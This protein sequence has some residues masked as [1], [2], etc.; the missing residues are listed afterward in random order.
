[1]H[2]IR[3]P[4]P[5][6]VLGL[7]LAPWIHGV[8]YFNQWAV[9]IL[10]GPDNAER[11]ARDLGYVNRGQIDNFKNVYFMEKSDHPQRSKRDA[12]HL[13]KR[14]TDDVR[15]VWAE[16][17]YAKKRV[18][19]RV[20]D[21]SAQEEHFF[22]DPL[23]PHQWYLKDTRDLR[24]YE[25]PKLDLNVK[26]CWKQ[27]FTGKDI[28]VS[29]VDDGLEWN[30]TDIK[31]NY[32]YVG[33]VLLDLDPYAST[34]VNDNDSDPFP[35][36]DAYNSNRHGTRCAG[37]IAMVANNAKC[38]VGVAYNAKIGGIRMLDGSLSDIVEGRALS[39]NVTH[40]DVFSASW[41]PS[42]DGR[43]VDGPG[44]LAQEAIQM[45]IKKGRKGK[46][47]IYVW[48]SGNGGIKGDNCNC[49]GY[50]GSI[51]TLSIGSASQH[52][53]FPWYGEK[54][55]STLACTYSSGAYTDQKISST[56]LHNECTID[57]TGTSAA[58]P[59]AAGIVALILEAKPK[60]TWRDV[61]HLVVWTSDYENLKKNS[62]WATN[63]IGLK[64]NSKFGFGMMN[65]ARMLKVA[66][67]WITV[68]EKHI[69][70]VE[71]SEKF[72]KAISSD[73]Q[74]EI[75]FNLKD[76]DVEYLEHVQVVVNIEYK[77]RGAL[78]IDLQS[79]S[80]TKTN[81]LFPRSKDVSSYGFQNWTFMSVHTW[82]ENPHGQWTAVIADKTSETN[83]GKVISAKLVVHGTKEMPEHMQNSLNS[84]EHLEEL[85]NSI[86]DEFQDN[87]ERDVGH[88]LDWGDLVDGR[89][90]VL[91]LHRIAAMEESSRKVS[92]TSEPT[93]TLDLTSDMLETPKKNKVKREFYLHEA[94]I[95][96]DLETVKKMLQCGKVNVNST[97]NMD[98]APIHWAAAHGH[99]EIVSLL[100][101]AKC[102][103]EAAD[104]Y[105]MRPLLLSAW[106]GHKE[107]VHVLINA[108]ADVAATN[109]QGFNLL[110][111]A[112]RNDHVEVVHFILDSLENVSPNPQD[113][114]QRT[115]LHLAV[116]HG[117]EKTVEE[118]IQSQ[119][120]LSYQDKCGNTALHMAAEHGHE[121][122]TKQLLEAGLDPNAQNNEGNTSLHTA[123]ESNNKAI[124]NTLLTHGADV[125]A[126]NCKDFTPLHTS[127]RRGSIDV[128]CLLL[129]NGADLEAKDK[130]GNTP[131][132]LSISAPLVRLL[133]QKN[134]NINASNKRLQTPLH[135]AAE[136]GNPELVEILLNA[137]A[138]FHLTEKSG[139]NV[140]YVAARGSFTAIVDLV[141]KTARRTSSTSYT[142][143]EDDQRL[144][145]MELLRPIFWNLAT[146]QLAP[147]DW[148]RLA[149]H[150]LFTDDQI[151]ALEHQYTGSSSYKE[152]GYRMLLIWLHGLKLEA[153]AVKELYEGLVAIERPDVA[154]SVVRSLDKQ[155]SHVV[156]GSVCRSCSVV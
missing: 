74:L 128:T 54:C 93:D 25:L 65:A 11:I 3:H 44:R 18:K 47:V 35:R 26:E 69:C 15:V 116:T 64:F 22:D 38:G 43:T 119:I 59:L 88:S 32:E 114:N 28:V 8:H 137:G 133:I 113:K 139:R 77:R 36:Y 12:S 112:A 123:V 46:G 56:D 145:R 49:D 66:Q 85:S 151:K 99:V 27:G 79:P 62:G 155:R 130:Y 9:H 105:G 106:Y 20:L 42:D 138:D 89:R 51:Y 91:V 111:C 68:P 127:V 61:Q 83:T 55:A 78:E 33:F 101:A 14:L 21:V 37:E 76:C 103:I 109:R 135:I 30:H 124:A 84:P 39:F 10:G 6:L 24:S 31:Q 156:R 132:H 134:A 100:I 146:K 60:L 126:R 82:G 147:T 153:N 96:N 121:N 143:Q 104:K 129:D 34:D 92:T 67:T 58:A 125:N 7:L 118:L 122:L 86:D 141:I 150:W 94:T 63:G 107:V 80:G 40:I 53:K 131:L 98:R 73:Q 108:G 102:N 16:Q 75:H 50:T 48:A 152:H 17:Q 41:G 71:A 45:G 52:G 148:K 81:L 13:T 90:C 97:N 115:P 142:T 136:R 120:K 144:K 2:F 70:H 4:I 19:R 29:I 5:L 140:L 57:H 72:P 154:Q 149:T 117:H 110:H 95:K 1:M 87:E 23:W